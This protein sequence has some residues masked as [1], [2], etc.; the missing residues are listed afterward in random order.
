MISP[1]H[2]AQLSTFY[3]FSTGHALIFPYG[4]DGCAVTADKLVMGPCAYQNIW[5]CEKVN[6]LEHLEAEL[7]KE[8]LKTLINYCFKVFLRTAACVT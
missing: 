5:I 4:Y 3:G 6:V 8:G 1:Q 2:W 7:N